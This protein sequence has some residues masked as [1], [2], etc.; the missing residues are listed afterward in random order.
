VPDNI[1][2]LAALEE[3]PAVQRE[4]SLKEHHDLS[5]RAIA[6]LGFR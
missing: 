5:W 1:V 6:F 2:A 4:V 3:V